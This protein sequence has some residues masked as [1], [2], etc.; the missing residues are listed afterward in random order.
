MTKPMPTKKQIEKQISMLGS[1]AII[2]LYLEKLQSQL[3]TEEVPDSLLAYIEEKK[4][5][6]RRSQHLDFASGFGLANDELRARAEQ[7]SGLYDFGWLHA[8]SKSTLEQL[9]SRADDLSLL[10][11]LKYLAEACAVTRDDHIVHAELRSELEECQRRV[12]RSIA[13]KIDHLRAKEEKIS[14]LKKQ[15]FHLKSLEKHYEG[16]GLSPAGEVLSFINQTLED[17]SPAAA[18]PGKERSNPQSSSRSRE[19]PELIRWKGSRDQRSRFIRGLIDAEWVPQQDFEAMQ[20]RIVLDDSEQLINTIT[21]LTKKDAA[22]I[23]WH[24]PAQRT[25]IYLFK[26]LGE[27]KLIPRYPSAQIA[28]I[29]ESNFVRATTKGFNKK[30]LHS[31]AKNMI[32]SGSYNPSWRGK[33]D[34]IVDLTKRAVRSSK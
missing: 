13:D 7:F 26:K 14:Y 28:S 27:E 15:R 30:S 12:T 29:I 16:F 17:L 34:K 32:L 9:L 10:D 2:E 1:P 18:S 21:Q 24:G 33:A 5:D 20:D 23:A 6:V 22:P 3:A 4:R 11:K 8:D 25:L 19:E 31:S